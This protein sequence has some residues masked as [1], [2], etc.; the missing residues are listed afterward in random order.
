MFWLD[1]IYLICA[2]DTL[3]K[4]RR[5]LQLS[6]MSTKSVFHCILTF[7]NPARLFHDFQNFEWFVQRW[8]ICNYDVEC[9]LYVQWFVL[10]WMIYTNLNILYLQRWMCFD[11][12]ERFALLLNDLEGSMKLPPGKYPPESC[13]RIFSLMKIPTMNIAPWKKNPLWKLLR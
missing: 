1:K 10:R 6:M 3:K 5:W 8:M 4:M 13:L 7:I 9:I 12:V 2:K 11:Y